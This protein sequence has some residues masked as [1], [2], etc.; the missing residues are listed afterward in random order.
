MEAHPDVWLMWDNVSPTLLLPVGLIK[1]IHFCVSIL[2]LA[3][4]TRD[5]WKP[6]AFIDSH[7]HFFIAVPFEGNLDSRKCGTSLKGFYLLKVE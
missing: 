3:L 7:R 6:A 4:Y 2:D 1:F 5:L